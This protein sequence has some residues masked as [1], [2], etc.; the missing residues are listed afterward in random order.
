LFVVFE[1]AGE[2]FAGG[3]GHLACAVEGVGGEGAGVD[4]FGLPEFEH[5]LSLLFVVDEGAGVLVLVGPGFYSLS[6]G[7]IVLEKAR[8]FDSV[9]QL[10]RSFTF[11]HVVY[12]LP[13]VDLFPIRPYKYSISLLSVIHKVA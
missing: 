9:S 13:F 10:K 3:P 5:S 7:G 1:L 8:V 2:G 12:K 6:G 4:D 11:L